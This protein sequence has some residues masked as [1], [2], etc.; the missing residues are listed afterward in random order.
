MF[1]Q[2]ALI[3][4]A[5][6]LHAVNLVFCQCSCCAPCSWRL[7]ICLTAEDIRNVLVR[8]V[9]SEWLLTLSSRQKSWWRTEAAQM[10]T[11]LKKSESS[12]LI[13]YCPKTPRPFHSPASSF[14]IFLAGS[15]LS[16]MAVP[17]VLGKILL[18]PNL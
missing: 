16:T 9:G 7:F 15:L 10:K 17:N 3:M 2:V 13:P 1:T 14:L 4:A 8:H 18:I 12:R 6:P 11:V 5:F